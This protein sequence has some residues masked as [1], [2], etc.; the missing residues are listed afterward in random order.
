MQFYLFYFTFPA[1][2]P[3]LSSEASSHRRKIHR[4][5]V[6]APL[7]RFSRRDEG[8]RCVL[9]IADFVYNISKF[10]VMCFRMSTFIAFNTCGGLTTASMDRT[11]EMPRVR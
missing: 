1:P 5:S 2:L 6:G 7:R 10:K 11:V 3:R 4:R 8:E 9:F